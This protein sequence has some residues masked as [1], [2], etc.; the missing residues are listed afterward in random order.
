M[1]LGVERLNKNQSLE[2]EAKK[3]RKKSQIEPE[4][5]LTF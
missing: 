3:E 1:K 5:N 2:H 4:T